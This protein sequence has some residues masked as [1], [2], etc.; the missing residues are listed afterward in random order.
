M[1][2]IICAAEKESK[3]YIFLVDR[4]SRDA[5]ETAH[6]A[7]EESTVATNS[8]AKAEIEHLMRAT[9]QKATAQAKQLAESTANKMA[10]LRA[11]AERK[12]DAAADLIVERIVNS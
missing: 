7:G 2:R 9:D 6:N 5:I 11:R 12:L 8:R 4:K 3:E 1:L 10:T